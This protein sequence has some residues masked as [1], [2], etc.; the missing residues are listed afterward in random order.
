MNLV[1]KQVFTFIKN[2]SAA[3]GMF[4]YGIRRRDS[5]PERVSDVKKTVRGTVL[6][7]TEIDNYDYDKLIM[8]AEE[9]KRMLIAS[10]NTAKSN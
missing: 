5:N 3:A 4:F 10:I 9:I 1:S 8:V 2:I 7:R 6:K